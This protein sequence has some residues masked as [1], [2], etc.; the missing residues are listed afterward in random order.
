MMPNNPKQ[1]RAEERIAIELPIRLPDAVGTTR[2]ISASGVF[3]EIDSQITVGSEISFEVEMH[4]ELD[5]VVMKGCGRIVRTERNG[6]RTG[7]AVK[8]THAQMETRE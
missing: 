1:K 3:F 6:S 2:N 4:I 5:S 8:I 7:V